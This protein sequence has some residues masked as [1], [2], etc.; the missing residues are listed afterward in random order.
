MFDNRRS[1]ESPCARGR[2]D[3]TGTRG[4]EDGTGS[5]GRG[6]LEV[7]SGCV[8][9]AVFCLECPVPC[10]TTDESLRI[11]SEHPPTAWPQTASSSCLWDVPSIPNIP[12]P[13]WSFLKLEEEE[14]GP[15]ASPAAFSQSHPLSQVRE[16]AVPSCWR[17]EGGH[18]LAIAAISS[19]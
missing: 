6:G 18:L 15:H 7:G 3:P 8:F 14:R 2:R 13:L 19:F 12:A 9:Q 16:N 11:S 4:I 5:V 10:G 17:R 1:Q